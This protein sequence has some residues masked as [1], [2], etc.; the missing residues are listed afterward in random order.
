MNFINTAQGKIVIAIIL[1][2]FVYT[3]YKSNQINEILDVT[4]VAK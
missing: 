4:P 3:I 2:M 1:L